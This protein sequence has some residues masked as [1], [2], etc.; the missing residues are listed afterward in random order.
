MGGLRYT[1]V[2]LSS[3]FR[4]RLNQNGRSSGFSRF[5]S[6]RSNSFYWFLSSVI[7]TLAIS[8]D[9]KI[10]D[11]N[12]ADFQRKDHLKGFAYNGPGLHS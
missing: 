3:F 8:K 10:I 5:P 6:F 1:L 7:S 9:A 11:P 12:I 4:E 2:V